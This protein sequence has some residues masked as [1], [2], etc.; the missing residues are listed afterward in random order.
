MASFNTL[1]SNDCF[2]LNILRNRILQNIIANSL[3]SFTKFYS[4]KKGFFVKFSNIS[5]I[6]IISVKLAMVL[7]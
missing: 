5:E 1:V 2:T 3:N 6:N 4:L 7:L